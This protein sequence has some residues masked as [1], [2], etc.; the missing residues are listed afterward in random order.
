[1]S[2]PGCFLGL[3][4]EVGIKQYKSGVLSPD[5]RVLSIGQH[6]LACGLLSLLGAPCQVRPD[7]SLPLAPGKLH[8]FELTNR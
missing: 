6:C 4:E 3:I 8:G 5:P 7:Q 1:M 2:S